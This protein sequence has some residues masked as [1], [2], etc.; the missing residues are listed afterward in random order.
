MERK[1]IENMN[2]TQTKTDRFS[3]YMYSEGKTGFGQ[4]IEF[5]CRSNEAEQVKQFLADNVRTIDI[6]VTGRVS[7]GHGAY[8]RYTRYDIQQHKYAGGGHG[9]C[10]GYIEVL[11]IKDSPDKRCN[12][13]I[14]E[15]NSGQGHIRSSFTEWNT[16]KNAITAFEKSRS[17]PDKFSELDGFIRRVNCGL[18]T[19]WFYAIGEQQLVGDYALPEGLQDDPVYKL[20]KIF[21]VMEEDLPVVKTCMGTRFVEGKKL[22]N[23]YSSSIYGKPYYYR[24]VY[25]NDGSIWKEG[26]DR[27][28]PRP[29]EEQDMWILDAINQFKA[30][31]AGKKTNFTINFLD[32]KKFVSQLVEPK[33]KKS[34]PEGDYYIVVHLKNK[35]EPLKGWVT[36]FKPSQEAPNIIDQITQKFESRG[37]TVERIEITKKKVKKNGQR[38]AGVFHKYPF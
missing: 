32:G 21:V 12:A 11:E 6:P 1:E 13:V 23:Y 18:L 26:H 16:I 8:G 19:P 30:L 22:D 15:Y 20:G 37:K 34:S 35:R 31:L 17:F 28:L 2:A 4:L 5:T 38:W 3:S 27:T 25:W 33:Q 7:V 29:L 24:L 9:G 10:G 36:D 14:Y